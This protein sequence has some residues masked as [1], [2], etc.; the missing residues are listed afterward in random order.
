MCG[1]YLF[2]ANEPELSAIFSDAAMR[3]N[4]TDCTFIGGEIFPGNT[5]PVLTGKNGAV[6]MTWGFPSLVDRRPHINAR[7]ETVASAK[8]FRQAM[9]ER[10]CLVPA[11]KYFEWRKPDSGRKEKYAFRLQDGSPFYMAGI[12]SD[13]GKFAILTRG[14]VPTL[15]DIH[16][17]MPV[18][19]PK[20]LMRNWLG[21]QSFPFDESVTGF[22]VEPTL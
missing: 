20:K 4:V 12:F 2:D 16:D 19:V 5:V 9:A 8:T 22:C 7:S 6:F 3:I 21:M 15:S 14:A 1:R 18:V 13:N 11:S 10:R 17:R